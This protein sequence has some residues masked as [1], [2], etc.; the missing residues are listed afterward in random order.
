MKTLAAILL[1]ALFLAAA[2]AVGYEVGSIYK[3]DSDEKLIR[4]MIDLIERQR[5]LIAEL[6]AKQDENIS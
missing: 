2:F 4:D 5:K 1:I 3:I 6:E